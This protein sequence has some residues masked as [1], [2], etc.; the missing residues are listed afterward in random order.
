MS[1]TSGEGISYAMNS[2]I[3]AGKAIAAS[4][5]TDAL[6]TYQRSVEDIAANIRRKLRLLPFL[7]SS[8]G[9]RT[10]GLMPSSI[11]SKVTERI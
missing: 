4:A 1:P 3:A 2:G 8:W 5:S 6:E 11:V 10:A 7:E 9:K